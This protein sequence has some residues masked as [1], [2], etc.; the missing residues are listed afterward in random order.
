MV[1]RRTT[2]AFKG[3]P[4]PEILPPL[5]YR[6][7]PISPMGEI[8]KLGAGLAVFVALLV[9]ALWWRGGAQPMVS[10]HYAPAENLEPYDVA[11]IDQARRT[12]DMAAYVLSDKPVV[13]AL[14]RAARRGVVV[15][16][17]ADRGQLEDR[18]ETLPLIALQDIPGVT[19]RVKRGYVYMH[20]KAYLV[21]GRWLRSGAGNFSASG[22]KQQDNDMVVV[23]SPALAAG[24]ERNFERIFA[25]GASE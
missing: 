9:A 19:L 20:L 17:L 5:N 8:L 3:T 22:L 25:E 15:R 24:F 4:E 1:E 11:L 16:I 7:R 14:E 21:D 18:P 13:E 2:P 12:I 23:D 6:T 10:I